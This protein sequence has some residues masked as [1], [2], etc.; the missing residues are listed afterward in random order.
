MVPGQRVSLHNLER[1]PSLLREWKFQ[2]TGRKEDLYR[3]TASSSFYLLWACQTKLLLPVSST[4][5]ALRKHVWEPQAVET[6]GKGAGNW[7]RYCFFVPWEQVCSLKSEQKGNTA[8]EGP[9]PAAR[10]VVMSKKS[11]RMCKMDAVTLTHQT[12]I[13]RWELSFS[14][15]NTQVLAGLSVLALKSPASR[16]V[17]GV[18]KWVGKNWEDGEGETLRT[19]RMRCGP[20]AHEMLQRAVNSFWEPTTS[21]LRFID[22]DLW[23]TSTFK[24]KNYQL[25]MVSQSSSYAFSKFYQ[26]TVRFRACYQ[27][28]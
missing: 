1:R 20:E 4:R 9:I 22:R 7:S 18:E 15:T 5:P 6:Q 28:Y 12:E 24:V 17:T 3:K 26:L 11:G 27:S 16:Q 2:N 10:L 25:M 23:A 21:H 14:S 13:P 19:W 8:T